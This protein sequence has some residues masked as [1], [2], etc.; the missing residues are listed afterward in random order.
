MSREEVQPNK[1]DEDKE[2]T[3]FQRPAFSKGK[4]GREKDKVNFSEVN[5]FDND[6]LAEHYMP[7]ED[8]EGRHRFDPKLQW[9]EEEEK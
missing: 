6:E 3:A 4:E 8:Y 7:R 9:T 5:V 2:A 1:F